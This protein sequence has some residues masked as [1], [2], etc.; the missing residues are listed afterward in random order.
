MSWSGVYA[1]WN[2]G[3]ALGGRTNAELGGLLFHNTTTQR[4][5]VGAAYRAAKQFKALKEL[6]ALNVRYALSKTKWY[7]AYLQAE[8]K[9]DKFRFF[10]GYTS[11][12]QH[13]TDDEIFDMALGR[14]HEKQLIAKNIYILENLEY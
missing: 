14:T 10:G 9:Y 3:R 12:I 1:H 6:L 4:R 13:L 5:A 7:Q 2:S 8:K 11:D